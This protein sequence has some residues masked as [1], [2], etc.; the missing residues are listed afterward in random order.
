MATPEE[1]KNWDKQQLALKENL[2]AQIDRM[3]VTNVEYNE[4]DATD[5]RHTPT[6]T[7]KGFWLNS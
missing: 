2:K 3:L 7:I 4:V 5:E 6:M 1:Q